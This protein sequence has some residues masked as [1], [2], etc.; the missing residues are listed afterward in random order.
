MKLLKEISSMH[1]ICHLLRL[2]TQFH[3]D[4]WM[5]C[6]VAVCSQITLSLNVHGVL[7]RADS[8]RPVPVP[9]PPLPGCHT[10][11]SARGRNKV[12]ATICM[13]MYVVCMCGDIELIVSNIN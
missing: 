4:N 1:F 2:S 10:D 11:I 12:T 3:N 5:L 13:C 7:I 8:R 6:E 9:V